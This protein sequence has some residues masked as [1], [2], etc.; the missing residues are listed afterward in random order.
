MCSSDL[1]TAVA[2]REHALEL[3]AHALPRAPVPPDGLEPIVFPH[4]AGVVGYHNLVELRVAEGTLT[5]GPCAVWFRLR[6]P[7]VA[8]EA[9]GAI[10]RVAVAADSGNG[11]SAELDFKRWIFVNSDLTINLLRPARGEWICIDARTLLGPAG[12]G[13]AEARIF[14]AE[15]L[16]GRSAQSPHVRAR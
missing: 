2:Q 1:F 11:I 7:L 10:E 3:P 8:G 4:R 9:P 6:H 16:I 15:G 5:R 14:D 12:G 13:V